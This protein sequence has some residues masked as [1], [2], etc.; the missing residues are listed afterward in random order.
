MIIDKHGRNLSIAVGCL[1]V[2]LSS[3]H[4]DGTGNRVYKCFEILTSIA[5]S[6]N[7]I[8]A[9]CQSVKIKGN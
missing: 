7:S 4:D 6:Y 1:A 9:P 5:L 3:S 2:T 8:I